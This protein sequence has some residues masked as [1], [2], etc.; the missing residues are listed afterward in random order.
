M[1]NE[2]YVQFKCELGYIMM[3]I[4]NGICQY[5]RIYAVLNKNVCHFFG[6]VTERDF[7]NIQSTGTYTNDATLLSGFFSET[8]SVTVPRFGF[9]FRIHRYVLT[10]NR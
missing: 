9:F 2:K 5:E 10:V 3:V 6:I 4:S 1:P 8:R 7:R